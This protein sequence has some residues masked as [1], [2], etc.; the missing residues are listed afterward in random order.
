MQRGAELRRE[1]E[2]A[3][4]AL[5]AV[6]EPAAGRGPGV[7]NL[8]RVAAGRKPPGR[9]DLVADIFVDLAAILDD[10]HG[11]IGKDGVEEIEEA[12]TAEPLRG[13]GRGA[14]IEKQQRPLLELGSVIAPGDE[15]DE[16]VDPE[17]IRDADGDAA[18]EARGQGK[19]DVV[20]L[21]TRASEKPLS[22][23]TKIA[24]ARTATTKSSAARTQSVMRKGSRL[25]DGSAHLR[26]TT[27]STQASAAPFTKPITVPVRGW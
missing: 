4:V 19:D 7:E 5:G 17:Q 27:S 20:G 12:P 22:R 3:P 9:D 1:A 25:N 18:D 6:R 24:L 10:R 8:G 16:N 23:G 26:I 11:K 13:R 15:G 14:Q 21:P 2:I